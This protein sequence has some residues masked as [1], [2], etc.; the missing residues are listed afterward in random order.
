MNAPAHLRRTVAYLGGRG[1]FSEEA[2]QRFLP[3]C[4]LMPLADFE[5]VATAVCQG[6]ADV[7]VL[8]IRNSVAGPIDAVRVLL[9]H[10]E[11]RMVGE[12]DV[13]IRLHLL[14]SN[15]TSLGAIRE[16]ASHRAA[17]RQCKTFL[18][19][20]QLAAV[21]AP[22]TS[23][24]ARQVADAKDPSRAAIASEVAADIYG[25]TIVARD[26]QGDRASITRF[27]IVERRD[28]YA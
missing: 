18:A 9:A 21:E 6:S 22:S 15:G 17:L 5:A 25:L 16:V 2:C 3:A 10:P 20:H 14:A 27:A 19:D 24:A 11:L 13:D 12:E 26:V 23:E 8:P 1:S 28:H 7:G 4:E